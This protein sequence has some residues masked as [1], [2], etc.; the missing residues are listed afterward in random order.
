MVYN[1]DMFKPKNILGG[2]VYYSDLI[3]ELEHF[4]TTRET[5][6]DDNKA[7]ICEYLKLTPQNFVHPTQTH[8]SNISFA[9]IGVTEYPDCDA[10]IL[11]NDVQG[12]YLRFAD[13]TPIILYDKSKNIGAIAHAGW[14]GSAERIVVKTIEKMLEYTK[15]DKT[16]IYAVI[17]PAIG[18][19]CYNI[20]DEV[21]NKLKNTVNNTDGLFR[22]ESDKTYVDLKLL[23]S[24]Q[25]TEYGILKD[26]IDIC[27]YCTACQND[28]FYSYRAESGTPNRHNAVIK[29]I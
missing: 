2:V 20:G 5:N 12:I 7:K 26:N 21:Y 9:K 1:K 17:G 28:L 10:L 29:L 22:V 4:F 6:V 25:M 8:S 14:R 19:C 11:T 15:S 13:C 24:R 23:N 18:G 27:P 3:P 16:S